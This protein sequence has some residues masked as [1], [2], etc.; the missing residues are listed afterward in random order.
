[1]DGKWGRQGVW[2]RVSALLSFH[3]SMGSGKLQKHETSSNELVS[4]IGRWIDAGNGW[5]VGEAGCVAESVGAVEFSRI[6]GVRKVT[7][8]RNEFER[9]RF[10]HWAVARRREWMARCGLL[11]LK[12]FCQHN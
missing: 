7:E 12:A 10:V 5:Q 6:H 11:P 4:C 8:T 9:T 1:M 3:G 2:L